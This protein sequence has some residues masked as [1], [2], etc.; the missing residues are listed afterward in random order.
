MR[1]QLKSPFMTSGTMTLSLFSLSCSPRHKCSN[2]WL[3]EPYYAME[4]N[5]NVLD[6]LSRN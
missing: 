5:H 6:D 2:L 4:D 1:K 3:N